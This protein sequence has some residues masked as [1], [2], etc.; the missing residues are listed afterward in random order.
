MQVG[1]IDP[2]RSLMIV[3]QTGSA[4]IVQV[5]LVLVMIGSWLSN[6]VRSEHAGRTGYHV[7]IAMLMHERRRMHAADGQNR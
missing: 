7:K 6:D 5:L 2:R 3:R 4:A 1:D